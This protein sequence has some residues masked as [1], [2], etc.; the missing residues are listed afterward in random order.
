MSSTILD[1]LQQKDFNFSIP[2][3]RNMAPEAQ[4]IAYYVKLDGEIVLDSEFITVYGIFKD[5]VCI[6]LNVQQNTTLDK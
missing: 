5:T 6:Q 3:A 2:G 1:G 4:I